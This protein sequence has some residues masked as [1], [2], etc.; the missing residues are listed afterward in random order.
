MKLISY[1]ISLKALIFNTLPVTIIIVFVIAALWVFPEKVIKGFSV[2]GNFI[3][4]TVTLLT[5]TAIFQQI[6]GIML[7]VLSVMS[8]PGQVYRNN[9]IRV[10]IPGMC[11]DQHSSRRRVPDDE[12][13][14]RYFRQRL[15]RVGERFGLD[16]TECAH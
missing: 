14:N 8:V 7:P 9:G 3:T 16:R 15:E 1:E 5:M 12:M 6:T 13:D 11:R 2:L 4:G 10:G